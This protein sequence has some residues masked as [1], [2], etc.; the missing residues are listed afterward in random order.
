M[1]DH[2][3]DYKPL[4]AIKYQESRENGFFWTFLSKSRGWEHEIV[5]KL[6]LVD[7]WYLVGVL[8]LYIC[9]WSLSYDYK[10]LGLLISTGILQYPVFTVFEGFCLFLGVSWV[11][12]LDILLFWLQAI[13]ALIL[14]II[15][16][17]YGYVCLILFILT[18]SHR[19]Y[20][21]VQEGP[22]LWCF[23]VFYILYN[24]SYDF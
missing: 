16:D 10:P 4:M 19:A 15:D 1:I 18:T 2:T 21:F 17:F 22:V 6:F 3:S 11:F 7:F 8:G 24:K 20:H 13:V 5:K 14:P 23:M 12:V 9:A